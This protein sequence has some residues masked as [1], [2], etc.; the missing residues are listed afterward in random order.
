MIDV[1]LYILLTLVDYV[2]VAFI[3]A[4]G[5]FMIDLARHDK[6]PYLYMKQEPNTERESLDV[7]AFLGMLWLPFLVLGP[8]WY[9]QMKLKEKKE[10]KN[11]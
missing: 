6:E 4:F 11:G 5:M 3:A 7:Y 10:N 9:I 1:I 2:T 8:I